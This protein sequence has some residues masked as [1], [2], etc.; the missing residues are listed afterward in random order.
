MADEKKPWAVANFSRIIS[1]RSRRSKNSLNR[2]FFS[3]NLGLVNRGI[4]SLSATT[5]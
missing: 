3:A 1:F 5:F 2:F 4:I